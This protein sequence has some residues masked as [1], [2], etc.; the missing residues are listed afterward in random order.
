MDRGRG[1]NRSFGVRRIRTVPD[2]RVD[3]DPRGDPERVTEDTDG[4]SET[5]CSFKTH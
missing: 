4:Y 3:E 5:I 1:G 2:H